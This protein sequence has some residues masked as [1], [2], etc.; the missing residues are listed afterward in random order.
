MGKVDKMV[1]KILGEIN[2][3]DIVENYHSKSPEKY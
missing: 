1:E 3:D 2:L